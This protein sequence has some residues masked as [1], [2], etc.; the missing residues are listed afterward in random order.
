MKRFKVL[1]GAVMVGTLAFGM[2][3]P[4]AGEAA[5]APAK[6][7]LNNN[8]SAYGRMGTYFQGSMHEGI[9]EKLGMTSEELYKA[10][11]DG[12]SIAD[13][14][15]EKDISAAEVVKAVIAE[16]EDALNDMVKAK[17][18][19]KDQKDLMLENMKVMVG[20]MI[21]TEGVGK[22]SAGAGFNRGG[23]CFMMPGT[24]QGMGRGRMGVGP[25]WW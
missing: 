6:V 11:L 2:T 25:M 12:K 9:A 23:G 3:N 18:I 24:N 8:V 10:R 16:R 22:G 14:L 21:N 20:N 7:Q 15:E 1:L 4:T 5:N 13:L 17:T 19:T